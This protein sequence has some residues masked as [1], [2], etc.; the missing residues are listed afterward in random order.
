MKRIKNIYKSACLLGLMAVVTSS[1]DDW[2][3][4]YPTDRVVEENFW[5]DRNDLDAVR[6]GAYKQMANT[7]NKMA[8]WGDLRSDSYNINPKSDMKKSD[9]DDYNNIIKGMP[10]S[11]MNKFDWAGFYTTINYCNKVLLHGPEVLERDK[12]FT[13]TEWNYIKAEMTALRALNYFYLIRSFKD[14]P[15]TREVINSDAEV[16]NFPQVNQLMVLDSIILDCESVQLMA[17]NRFAS[18]TDTKGMIT[19]PAIYAMLA[20]MY[21]WRASLHEGRYGIDDE[22]DF[23]TPRCIIPGKHGVKFDYKVAAEYANKALMALNEQTTANFASQY[24]ASRNNTCNY[25]LQYCDMIENKFYGVD[26]NTSP[27]ME[28][29]SAIFNSGNSVESIFELQFNSSPD[30]RE[31]P[32]INRYYGSNDGTLLMVSDQALR[33]ALGGS[34]MWDYDTRRWFYVENAFSSSDA[35]PTQPD[36]N[37][38]CLKYMTPQPRFNDGTQESKKLTYIKTNGNKYRNWI[39]YRMTDVMLIKA[40]ALACLGTQE[41]YA[42]AKN[43]CSA[44]RRRSYCNYKKFD[45][46]Q[47]KD[48][49]KTY[50]KCVVNPDAKGKTAQDKDRDPYIRMVMNERQI[51]LLGEGKRWY[52]LVRWAERKAGQDAGEPDVREALIP[53]LH[54]EGKAIGNGQ[55]GVEAMI[56]EFMET[57]YQS[58]GSTFKNRWKNR[59]GL[60]NPIYYKEVQASNGALEQNPVWNH[61]KYEQ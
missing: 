11:S 39:V 17:R 57:A 59:Y 18:N 45:E 41:S 61:S 44:I 20:D 15:F 38:Y 33:A 58:W 49:T 22:D 13:A 10:D 28:A 54:R 1:C 19:K 52:D 9:L 29:Q 23:E 53:E 2:L 6:Y 50:D 35:A 32:A 7:V 43:L 40:E 4:I 47:R 27:A 37:Y 48:L 36:Q 12:Q 25:G 51:E 46:S 3:T 21:L 24:N 56:K 26:Q 30:N 60:Y 16:K 31:N 5:E 8:E 42:E 55:K 34:E 14:V